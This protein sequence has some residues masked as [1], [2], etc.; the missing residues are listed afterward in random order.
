MKD[1]SSVTTSSLQIPKSLKLSLVSL[2][3]ISA[4]LA[5]KMAIKVFFTPIAYPTPDRELHYRNNLTHSRAT[6][7]NKKITVFSSG[8]NP[9]V[10][11]VHGWCGRASQ[12]YEIGPWF[13]RS[14]LE[15]YSF[16]AP[17]H[18]SSTDR[19]SNLNEF[20][21]CIEFMDKEYGPFEAI[22][23]H[24]LGGVAAL[25]YASRNEHIKKV[26][27]IGTPASITGTINDFCKLLGANK[28]VKKKLIEY[29]KENFSQTFEEQSAASLAHLVKAKG[30]I[31]HDEDDIDAN[32]KDAYKIADNWPGAETHITKG[33]GH[34]RILSDTSVIEKMIS[35]LS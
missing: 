15:Y 10:L 33:L 23:G 16:T 26:I 21:E 29:I 12:F 2:Q 27:T 25:N 5:S 18:G 19:Q 22:V 14:G 28:K 11:L 4:A 34:R 8:S 30:L 9:K 3:A 31:I 17:A 13:V 6:V 24:S 1:A 20:I 32:V 7:N 35:F